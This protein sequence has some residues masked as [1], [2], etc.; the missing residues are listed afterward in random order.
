MLRKNGIHV[1]MRSTSVLPL[2][3]D[4]TH[5][6]NCWQLGSLKCFITTIQF[7]AA[8]SKGEHGSMNSPK[9]LGPP[10]ESVEWNPEIVR[11]L[12]IPR[13]QNSLGIEFQLEFHWNS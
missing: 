1:Y 3:L 10:L 2:L 9:V 5:H 12:R 11:I 4:P 6:T 7:N 8:V 13:I